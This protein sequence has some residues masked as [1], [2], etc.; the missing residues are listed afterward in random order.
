MSSLACHCLKFKQHFFLGENS[1]HM[2][3][4]IASIW[5]RLNPPACQRVLRIL[6]VRR[7]FVC[8]VFVFVQTFPLAR[9]FVSPNLNPPAP[10]IRSS[11]S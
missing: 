7:C 5:A 9:I 1:K 8:S 4:L 2:H 10:G 6:F 11:S 3:F